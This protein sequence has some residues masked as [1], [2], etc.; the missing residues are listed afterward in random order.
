MAGGRTI[1][2][3]VISAAAG[4]AVGWI[5]HSKIQA[6]GKTLEAAEALRQGKPELSL[7]LAQIQLQ[8]SDGSDAEAQRIVARSFARLQ[9]WPEAVKAFEQS[10]YAAAE[11][12][13][14][15]AKS[16]FLLKR[17]ADALAVVA[18]GLATH[19]SDA[20]LAETEA[21]V[22]AFINRTKEA[23]ASAERLSEMPGR[24]VTAR[25]LTGM[26]HY[27]ANNYLQAAEALR[28]ALKASPD[29]SG[30]SPD[31]PATSVE[32]VSEMI[33]AALIDGGAASE[34]GPFAEA[35]F[36]AKPTGGRAHLA[37]KC[38]RARGDVAGWTAWLD[39]LFKLEPDHWEGRMLQLELMLEQKRFADAGNLIE[40]LSKRPTPSTAIKHQIDVA[41]ARI[42]SAKSKRK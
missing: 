10:V 19:P 3:A 36:R 14:L 20:S 35:A 2:I 40:N 18:Q 29:L 39:Q 9:R 31:F 27:E 11:D 34:G 8:K 41:K 28:T 42:A 17:P 24:E 25:L 38:A 33:A 26:I 15:H 1:I 22:L 13:H 4:A 12:Y 5:A 23:L 37:A 30:Q 7:R 21:R 16:L 6:S 32:V